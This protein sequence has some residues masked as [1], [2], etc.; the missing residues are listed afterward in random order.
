MEDL[1]SFLADGRF[2][3]MPGTGRVFGQ[4]FSEFE[5][6]ARMHDQSPESGDLIPETVHK[7]FGKAFCKFQN[8][9]R[10]RF[11]RFLFAMHRTDQVAAP[12]I[13]VGGW[14]STAAAACSRSAAAHALGPGLNRNQGHGVCTGKQRHHAEAEGE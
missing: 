9:C 5:D 3:Q 14:G 7:A 6:G 2:Q 13:N 10:Q 8:P 1:C 12:G 4:G 11:G